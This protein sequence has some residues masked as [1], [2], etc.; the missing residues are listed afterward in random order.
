MSKSIIIHHDIPIWTEDLAVAQHKCGIQLPKHISYFLESTL[1]RFIDQP[2]FNDH[3]FNKVAY[4]AQYQRIPLPTLAD[5]ADS[6]LIYIGLF[7]NSVDNCDI[8]LA[9]FIDTGKTLYHQIDLHPIHTT[10]TITGATIAN[11]Y[12]E[13]VDTLLSFRENIWQDD[14]ITKHYAYQLWQA[15]GSKYALRHLHQHT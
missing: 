4:L 8:D 10:N 15:S 1:L 3:S 11:H 14:P 13:L 7:P 12:I 5:T 2:L 9:H 6:C